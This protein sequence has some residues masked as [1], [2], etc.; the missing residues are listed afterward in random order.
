MKASVSSLRNKALQLLPLLPLLAYRA[1]QLESMQFN[2]DV[3]AAKVTLQ[4]GK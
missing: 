1:Y 2:N 4:N 3:V